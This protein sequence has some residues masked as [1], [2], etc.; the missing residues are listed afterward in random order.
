[1]SRSRIAAAP[2]V[3]ALVA[4]LGTPGAY[5]RPG[6]R[7]ENGPPPHLGAAQ[8]GF[9]RGAIGDGEWSAFAF[10]CPPSC[11]PT[12]FN[13]IEGSEPEALDGSPPASGFG[14]WL[15]T[16]P[17]S[18]SALTR[19]TGLG[20]VSVWFVRWPELQEAIAEGELTILELASLDSLRVGTA[21]FEDA[22]SHVGPPSVTDRRAIRAR[23]TLDGGGSLELLAAEDCAKGTDVR[24]NWK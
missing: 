13:L 16:E 20:T 14:V 21:T 19:L 4:L 12:D 17:G 11:V 5:V 23:V 1:M 15:G 7:D 22:R 3:A 10:Y 6:V 9:Q 24:L 8:P 2:G 18:F